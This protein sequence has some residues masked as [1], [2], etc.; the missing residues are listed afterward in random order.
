MKTIYVTGCLSTVGIFT[1]NKLLELGYYVIGSDN[2]SIN[3][4]ERRDEIIPSNA[5]RLYDSNFYSEEILFKQYNIDAILHLASKTVAADS[6][7]DPASYC[8][9]NITY[10][11]KL[12]KNAVAFN[13]PRFVFASSSAVYGNSYNLVVD[14]ITTTLPTSIYGITKYAS[15]QLIKCFHRQYG[16]ETISLRYYNIFA[17]IHYYSVNAIVPLFANKIWNNIPI[18]LFN[19]GQQRRQFVHIDNIVEANILAL[20]TNNTNCFGDAFNITVD[21]SPIL[22]EDLVI[23]LYDGFLKPY[24]YT[25]SSEVTAGDIKVC[26]GGISKAKHLLGYSVVKNIEDGLNDYITWYKK[27]YI[28]LKD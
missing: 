1:I 9:T 3:P 11:A 24:N 17:P 22:L 12:L 7:E 10:T 19:E 28:H 21:E 8:N 13:I 15:E 16:L 20:E 18:T 2:Y 6:F 4:R 25:L 5:F 23:K 27:T 14:E 26:W